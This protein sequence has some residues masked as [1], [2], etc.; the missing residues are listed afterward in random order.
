MWYSVLPVAS[1]Y[2][3]TSQ[4]F[5][6]TELQ[7]LCTVAVEH[8]GC[9]LGS[10]SF[11]WFTWRQH[12]ITFALRTNAHALPPRCTPLFY[13]ARHLSLPLSRAALLPLCTCCAARL[14]SWHCLPLRTRYYLLI[15]VER[16]SFRG[17][18]AGP[19]RMVHAMRCCLCDCRYHSQ[20]CC[21]RLCPVISPYVNER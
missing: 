14:C 6:M 2:L 19:F 13:T 15:A 3:H 11:A 9:W 10:F 8:V 18:N 21:M 1:D 12:S 5:G 16:W 20:C 17:V 7:L 4:W